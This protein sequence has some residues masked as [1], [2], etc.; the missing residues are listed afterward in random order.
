MLDRGNAP[1]QPLELPVAERRGAAAVG[2]SG[3]DTPVGDEGLM[4]RVV[5]RRNL[6]AALA[7]VQR[8]GG[9]PGMDGRTVEG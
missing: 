2:A 7:R 1:A 3:G 4:E 9:S 5:E 8:H 6:H